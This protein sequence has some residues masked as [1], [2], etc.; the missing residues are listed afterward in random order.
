MAQCIWWL[1]SVIGLEPELVAY[2]DRLHGRTVV[3]D[4]LQEKPTSGKEVR[5]TPDKQSQIPE[6]TAEVRQDRVFRQSDEYRKDSRRLRDI[7][8]LKAKGRTRTGRINPTSITR[9]K[10]SRRQ[11]I[12]AEPL[13]RTE[14]IDT[15]EIQ[16]WKNAG[17]CLR[18][19]W[20]E[21]SRGGYRVKDC[22]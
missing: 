14:V 10:L 7:T 1:V 6:S 13:G 21:D 5:A 3:E 2:I 16:R 22:I 11:R 17:E 9:Q 4:P 15:A 12:Q 8:G 18:C 19:A 20:P